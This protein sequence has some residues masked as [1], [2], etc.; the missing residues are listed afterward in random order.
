[1]T[2]SPKPFSTN[3][4]RKWFLSSVNV[5]VADQVVSPAEFLSTDLTPVQQYDEN[6]LDG[7]HYLHLMS[8]WG[9]FG[10]ALGNISLGTVLVT[11]IESVVGFGQ[12]RLRSPASVVF[13]KVL[14][15]DGCFVEILPSVGFGEIL[16]AAS[17]GEISLISDIRAWRKR[18]RQGSFRFHSVLKIPRFT[19]AEEATL[20]SKHVNSLSSASGQNSNMPYLCCDLRLSGRRE[21][22]LILLLDSASTE[23]RLD[24][25]EA[26]CGLAAS[27]PGE[28]GVAQ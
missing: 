17:F 20:E 15:T 3:F 5:L 28:S 11:R 9:G 24:S 18:P 12:I 1:M 26:R 8:L 27:M 6:G 23:L 21:R 7:M 2:A 14:V 25:T 13:G 10:V 19:R 4:A 16:A 22:E